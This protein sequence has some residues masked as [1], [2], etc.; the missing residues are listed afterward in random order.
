MSRWSDDEINIIK[1]YYTEY[2]VSGCRDKL[3]GRSDQ[4]IRGKAYSIGVGLSKGPGVK[5]NNDW[6]ESELFRKEIDHF[7]L[8]EYDGYDTPIKHEC[9]NGHITL[10]SPNNVL[11][12]TECQECIGTKKKTS[13][14][15][16]SQLIDIGIIYTPLEEYINTDTPILHSCPK[17]NRSWKAKPHHILSGHG[18][19]KCMRPGGY[20]F[21]YFEKNPDVASN[22]GACYLVV[23]IDKDTNKKVA[24]KIGITKGSSN[25]DVLK[26]VRHFKEYEA[27]ILKVHFDTLLNVF[28]L[29]Q[30]LH[31]K[32][33][34][35]KLLPDKKFGG[36]QECFELNDMIVKTFPNV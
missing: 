20:N 22:P 33:A 18:C 28:T 29:E 6:Y 32:W 13:D 7:P 27:R 9:L 26:R 2:G 4:A 35:Y 5:H 14:S 1:Q 31:A 34:Q 36:W 11:R 17:C 10:R 19:P 25:K 30:Q 8:E 3:P 12:N 16:Q 23:L 24:Y 21:S 15:Y